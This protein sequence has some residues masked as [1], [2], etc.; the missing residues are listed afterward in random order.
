MD[1]FKRVYSNEEESKSIAYFWDHFDKENYS[2]WFGEYKYNHELQKVFM[3]CNLIS[4][5]LISSLFK[6]CII[7]NRK[8]ILNLNYADF[9]ATAPSLPTIIFC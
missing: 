8:Y 7:I 6:L 3:S 2:I 1:E 4:G 5:K 9:I